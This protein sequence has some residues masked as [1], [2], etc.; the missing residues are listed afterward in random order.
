MTEDDFGVPLNMLGHHDE[1]FYSAVG[2]IAA[3]AALLEDRCLQLLR[4]IEDLEPPDSST[5]LTPST[6]NSGA[7]SVLKKLAAYDARLVG[8]A[9]LD[10]LASFC[11]DA[12]IAVDTR[13]TVI[14]SLWPAQGGGRLFGHRVKIGTDRTDSE[15]IC[16]DLSMSKLQELI[17]ELVW[18]NTSFHR[19]VLS[20]GTDQLREEIRSTL[21]SG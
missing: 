20:V 18:L 9:R 14:H 6:K 16:V 10:G 12:G 2:R 21:R 7:R 8:S 19:M 17:T 13:N 1:Q 15:T 4:S 11:E 3:L 5:G